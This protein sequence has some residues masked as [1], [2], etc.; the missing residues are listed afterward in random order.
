MI[1]LNPGPVNLSE[2]VRR[3]LLRPDLCHRE[4]E[5][6]MLQARIREGLLGVYGLDPA[7]WTVV[8]LTGS[9]TA[10]MEAMLITLVPRAGRLLVI[11]NGVYGERLGR[12]A[13]IHSL[14]YRALHH[15][16]TDPVDLEALERMLG[17]E[18]FTHLALVHHETTTGRLNDLHAVAQLCR[19]HGV[20]LLVDAVSSY[21]AEAIAFED[22][23]IA[24][25]AATA[26]KCL[27]GIPGA[28]LV[29]VRRDALPG[30][31]LPPRSLYL[32]LRGYLVQQDAGTTPFTQSV[33]AFYALDEAL[34]ELSDAGGRPA[35]YAQYRTLAHTVRADLITLGIRPL[36]PEEQS[37]VV[38]NAYHLPADIGYEPLH[39]GLKKAGF[40]IYAGQGTLARQIF[41]VSTMGAVTTSDMDRF[42]ASL[43]EIIR[44]R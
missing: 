22:C 15:A 13:H 28:A 1:L 31:E 36:L 17:E 7:R 30:A 6:A 40:V 44:A 16:W 34:A 4:P 38:L 20:Q 5:F 35:R 39:D 14:P 3:A 33:Q 24:G 29:V 2:R 19:P 23:S 42:A 43:A 32:D 9:G 27:H 12:I 10:A 26:N 8:L 21:G 37:S 18:P 11:E 41:R 25:C